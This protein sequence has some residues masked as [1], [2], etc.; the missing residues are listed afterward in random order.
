MMI[1]MNKTENLWNNLKQENTFSTG[2]VMKRYSA[3]VIPDVFIALLMPE[4][5]RSIAFRF[6]KEINIDLINK[7]NLKDIR[8][9]IIQDDSRKNKQLLV[10]SLSDID[11][12]E[13][14]SVFCEDLIQTVSQIVN[15][16]ELYSTL[17]DRF[18]QWQEL[19]EKNNYKP[20]SLG[21]QI[22]LFGELYFLKNSI[23]KVKDPQLCVNFW[24]GPESGIR[25]FE[26][27][28]WAVEVKTTSTHNQQKL[29]VNSERQLDSSHLDN[30]FLVHLSIELRDDSRL[31]LNSIIFD[32]RELISNHTS[33]LSRFNLKL[34]KAGYLNKDFDFY[35]KQGY[36][37]RSVN[38]YLVSDNFPRIEERDLRINV[39]D[40]KYSIIPPENEKYKTSVEKILESIG[41]IDEN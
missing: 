8:V 19:F 32:I 28:L 5:I 24:K 35:E 39:G 12:I 27:N 15:D 14:F 26:Y 33:A 23:L 40:V 22:G 13:I 21:A 3:E 38:Y 4:K 29:Y 1:M 37:I 9:Q 11:L 18:Q 2:I 31:T 7:N 16:T 41:V 34:I 25:D 36:E 10:F 6:D 17:L 30:L 20:L